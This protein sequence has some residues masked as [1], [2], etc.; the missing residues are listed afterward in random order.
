MTTDR[1]RV[2]LTVVFAIALLLP[3]TGQVAGG[4]QASATL[5]SGAIAFVRMLARGN[6]DGA[7]ADF[8]DQMKQAL[9]PAKL[10]EVW[11]G[12]QSQAGPFQDTGDAKTVV[13]GGYTT[14]VVTT[15]FKQQAIG[16]AVTFDSAR[17]IAGMH[18]VPP[19]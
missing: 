11:T 3:I 8:T 19:P 12:V 1:R 2:S 5:T 10:S 6:F 17:K 18:F 4:Q 7:E 9:P 15:K 13:Q 16:I 14:V